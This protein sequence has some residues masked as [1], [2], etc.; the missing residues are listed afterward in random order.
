MKRKRGRPKKSVVKDSIPPP[1]PPV[2]AD[3]AVFLNFVGQNVNENVNQNENENSESVELN[4]NNNNKKKDNNNNYDKISNNNFNQLN[5]DDLEFTSSSSSASSSSSSSSSEEESDEASFNVSDGPAADRRVKTVAK[6]RG[7]PKKG[8]AFRKGTNANAN[9]NAAAAMVMSSRGGGANSNVM[10]SKGGGVN[11]NVMSSKGGGVNSNVMSSKGGGGFSSMSRKQLPQ[12]SKK[13][14]QDPRYNKKALNASLAVIKKVMEMDEA[15]PFNSPV[16]PV[17]Q[18]I[19][20]YFTVIDT[21]MDFGTICSNLENSVKYMNS[22]DVYKDVGYIW[23][24]CCRFNKKG[25]YIMYLMK[26]VKKKFMKY[27]AAAGLSGNSYLAPSSNHAMRHSRHEAM[28][29]VNHLVN[30]NQ[31]QHARFGTSQPQVPLSSYNLHY[32]SHQPQ[33]SIVQ[34]PQFSQIQ[35][36]VDTSYT[37]HLPMPGPPVTV[38]NMERKKHTPRHPIVPMMSGPPTHSHQQQP[39]PSSCY[40]WQSQH[41]TGMPQPSHSHIGADINNAGHLHLPSMDGPMTYDGC[42]PRSSMDPMLSSISQPQPQPQHHLPNHR[43]ASE[44]HQPQVTIAQPRTAIVQP[45]PSQPLASADISSSGMP[46]AD[47]GKRERRHMDRYSAG[48]GTEIALVSGNSLPQQPSA[49]HNHMYK[50]EHSALGKKRKVR[51]PTRCR[52]MWDLPEGER[53][54]IPI[55]MLGQPIGPEASKLASFLGTVARDGKMAPLNFLDWSA[56]PEAN[57]EEMWQFVQTKFEMDPI[58]KSWVL[59]SLASKWRN[60]KAKLKA[61]HYNPHATDEERLKDCNKRVLPDQ[62]AA[63]IA[64]W[65]SEEVQLRCAK[66]KANR[67]KQKSAHAAGSKSFARI[68]EEE[69]AKRSNGK[70][71]TRGELYI[72]TRTRKDGQPVDSTA[73]EMIA[74]LREHATQK[75]QISDGSNDCADTYCQV[76]GEDKRSHVRMYGLGPSPSDIYGRKPSRN[77]LMRMAIEAKRSAN[78]EVSKMLNKM[79]AMEQKYASLEAQIASMSTNLQNVI[80]KMDALSSKQVPNNAAEDSLQAQVHSSSSSHAVELFFPFKAKWTGLAAPLLH[81]MGT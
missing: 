44:S 73:A 56:M 10:S 32:Q 37:G 52:L 72:L 69:N 33:P 43:Q 55:N 22:E 59:K 53:I 60:W 26:R 41:S 3:E 20:D 21:P 35:A 8:E 15:V 16:D 40:L 38:L 11:S 17:A 75:Q 4:R 66:N 50:S 57:K 74:K 34:G 36:G 45:Q 18:G 67:A 58:C 39:Q 31:M 9:V 49:S 12:L 1:P 65:N 2:N 30:P 19:P 80:D 77:S 29:V 46:H 28:S 64:H 14:V 48:P 63:L 42:V 13:P 70:E 71:L 68:R 7:R 23:E 51:G 61:D 62:W 78:E 76:M 27:W 25:D 5:G 54:F 24:N 47:A 81:V 79:E 6:R